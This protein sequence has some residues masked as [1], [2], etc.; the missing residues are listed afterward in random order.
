[1][2]RATFL[3]CCFILTI[4]HCQSQDTIKFDGQPH[5][6]TSL[7]VADQSLFYKLNGRPNF[8][9]GL[10]IADH[11]LFYQETSNAPLSFEQATRQKFVPFDKRLR[12]IVFSNRPLVIQWFKFI[13][14]NRSATDTVDL[15]LSVSLHYFTRL[16]ANSKLI[17]LGGAFQN[18]TEG[19]VFFVMPVIVPPNTTITYLARTEDRQNQLLPPT[20]ILR[21]PY[22]DASE[23]VI[24]NFGNRF[25]FM[26][27][28]ALSGCLFFICLYAVYQYYLYRDSAIKWYIAYAI[29]SCIV[30]L[31]WMDIRLQLLIFPS[32]VRD[33]VF[34]VFIF[35]VPVL[36]SFFIGSMLRFSFHFKKGWILVKL[37]TFIAVFQGVVQFIQ[38]GFGWFVFNP[39]WFGAVISIGPIALLNIVLLVLTVKSKDPVKWFLFVGLLS[40]LLLWS[41][42]LTGIFAR[43]PY[44][45]YELYLILIFPPAFMMLGITVEA[46]CFSFALSYRSKLVLVE[47]NNL[48]KL[49]SL[50]LETA[51]QQRTQE[52]E[53]QSK[54]VEEQK[55]KQIE[56]AF[57]HRIAETQMTALRAQMNPHFIFNC[58]NSIKLYTLENDGKTASEYLTMFSQLIRQVLENSHS[59]KVTLKK[60]L[61]TLKLYIDLEGMRFKDKVQ[62]E[63][64]VGPGIDQQ[65]TE[66]PP[67]LLQPYVENAIWH[68][69]M[70]KK[71]GG[72]LKIDVSQ[73]SENLLRVEIT[74]NGI[75][76]A[77]AAEYK[78]KSVMRQKSFGM[79]M[80]SERIQMI[81]QFYLVDTETKIIDLKDDSNNAVGTMVIIQIPI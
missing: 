56:T 45:S 37:L 32:L 21:T 41:L 40:M 64:N 3:A 11:T 33:I 81:N 66:V 76:R 5:W 10:D 25:I 34:S 28:A 29:M 71:Q 51:L 4:G 49:H 59:E 30:C 58:L 18:P 57:E 61:E 15:R 39:D 1:M 47:K 60:E 19:P 50:E 43:L 52:L 67:L 62:Y 14:S 68:G 22:D 38:V 78:S 46:I 6:K 24:T 63:I 77:L 69:L 48:Q 65:Y 23:K 7:S 12:R 16:Y 53:L 80:T 75:G 27:L 26:L 35:F 42:S 74:D 55:I 72:N 36:Y 79:T 9:T 54:L 31:F 20:V 2:R 17:S 70:H 73:P 13:I 44:H 8:K